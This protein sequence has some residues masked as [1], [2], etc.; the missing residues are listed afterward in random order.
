MF[1]EMNMNNKETKR[2]SDTN[3]ELYKAN[4]KPLRLL[5]GIMQ[6]T[7]QPV[8]QTGRVENL[9]PHNLQMTVTSTEKQ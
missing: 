3:G 4:A 7:K 2:T 8:L 6:S 9:V 5:Q 1:E